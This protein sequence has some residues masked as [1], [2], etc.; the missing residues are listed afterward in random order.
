MNGFDLFCGILTFLIIGCG[1]FGNVLSFMIWTKGR[2][3][4]KLPGGIYLRAL[5]VSD[6]IALLI[7]AFNEAVGLVSSITTKEENNFLC[8]L[9]TVGRHFGLMVSSWI[10]VTFT[11]ERTVAVFR[12]AATTNLVSKNGT[13]ALMTIIFVVSL[14]MN[15]PYGIVYGIKQEAVT[16]PSIANSSHPLESNISEGYGTNST[17]LFDELIVGYNWKCS[18]DKASLFNFENWYHIWLMDVFLIFIIPFTLMTGSN[19]IVVYL[20]FSRK[21]SMISKLDSKIKSVT[22]RA[23]TISVMHCITSG[24]FTMSTLFPEYLDKALNVRYSNEYYGLLITYL[25]AYTNHAM[26]FLI[27][28]FF[29]TDFRRDC[30]DLFL[31]NRSAVHPECSTQQQKKTS[32]N[33]KS[34]EKDPSLVNTRMESETVKTNVSTVSTF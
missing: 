5:A 22:M 28:S 29:G 4:K 18:A 25:L 7:P 13:I 19:V 30:A 14:L 2:R 1:I 10:I 27:Y 32:P 21:S 31:K 26:N 6:T 23:V 3:C 9:E 12:P 16:K 20:L 34:T 15:I 33:D 11:L 17:I 8:K 24:S